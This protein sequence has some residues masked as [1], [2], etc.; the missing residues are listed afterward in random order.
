MTK[1]QRIIKLWLQGKST[2]EIACAVYGLSL[3]AD[4]VTVD[5][6]MA[7]VRVVVRQRPGGTGMS[8]A[9]AQYQSSPSYIKNK[10]RW[11]RDT[12]EA[13]KANPQRHEARKASRRKRNRTKETL[14]SIGGGT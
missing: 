8:S 7:Y 12:W 11:N 13:I 3:C 10:Q 9:Q 6:C 4:R 1:A 2:R 14:L 5:K